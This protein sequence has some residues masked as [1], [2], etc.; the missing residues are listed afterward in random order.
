M[1]PFR[2][3]ACGDANAEALIAY[4][5]AADVEGAQA[6]EASGAAAWDW[7]LEHLVLYK[8]DENPGWYLAFDTRFGTCFHLMFLG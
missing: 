4:G 7:D 6:G 1:K 2:L 3:A 8:D 5:C